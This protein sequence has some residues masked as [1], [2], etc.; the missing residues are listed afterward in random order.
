MAAAR[1]FPEGFHLGAATAAFQIEG[2]AAEDGKRDSIWDVFCREPG[3][4]ANG[5]DGTLACDHYHRMPSDVQLMADLGLTTYR[6]SISWP[7]V[8]D[9]DRVNEP[10]MDFYS[11]LVDELL[12]RD[13]T[14]G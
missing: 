10:G 8:L 4:V 7:R 14:P 3:R 6:F 1:Q 5:D 12:A 11:R 2:A 9:G 13:I